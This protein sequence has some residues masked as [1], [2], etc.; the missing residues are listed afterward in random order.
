MKKLILTALALTAL[1]FST[2]AVPSSITKAGKCKIQEAGTFDRNKLFKIDLKNKDVSLTCSFRFKDF[3]G[4]PTVFAIPTVNNLS[5][6]TCRISYN[7]AFF[8]AKNNLVAAVSQHWNNLKPDSKNFQLGSAM[9]SI[10]KNDIARITS[11]KM[12]IYIMKK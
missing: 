7:V 6:Q 8:D 3:F 12:V 1:S 2:Y 5:K 10:P 9:T 4:T 11:Y